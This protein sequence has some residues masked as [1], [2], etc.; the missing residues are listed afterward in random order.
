MRVCV[1]TH[2]YYLDKTNYILGLIINYSNATKKFLLTQISF[3]RMQ[4]FF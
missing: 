3:S 1:Y 2:I 4:D